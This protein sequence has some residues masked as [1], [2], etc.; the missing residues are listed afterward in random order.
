MTTPIEKTLFPIGGQ[1]KPI[2]T[3]VVGIIAK[4][5]NC[6]QFASASEDDL[7]NNMLPMNYVNFWFHGARSSKETTNVDFLDLVLNQYSKYTRLQTDERHIRTHSLDEREEVD[8]QYLGIEGIKR[9]KENWNYENDDDTDAD[10]ISK[11][12]S[13]AEVP[14]QNV[15]VLSL[16]S[17][18]GFSKKLLE[19][20]V[21]AMY[22]DAQVDCN[23]RHVSL[24]RMNND[25]RADPGMFQHMAG[26]S[27]KSED[28]AIAGTE[29]HMA[30][31]EAIPKTEFLQTFSSDEET[32]RIAT[33]KA[34]V[35]THLFHEAE[36]K[37]DNDK[38]G[39][40]KSNVSGDCVACAMSVT[41]AKRL[42]FSLTVS[43]LAVGE[44]LKIFLK[45]ILTKIFSVGTTIRCEI[46]HQTS[47]II[48]TRAR[49]NLE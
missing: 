6:P 44:H 15:A 2:V 17:S 35:M 7:A 18:M 31:A 1:S 19:E 40:S 33:E 5:T 8:P 32:I 37:D 30:F 47:Q 34:A 43:F 12:F 4:A 39:K 36:G 42:F 14:Y 10:A 22:F 20:N 49:D 21:F 46:H 16:F 11:Y 41:S 27:K 26:I 3:M 29:C 9:A 45:S 25:S 24:E 28:D 23:N 13:S 48:R 38:D